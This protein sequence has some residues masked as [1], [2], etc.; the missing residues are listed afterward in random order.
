MRLCVGRADEVEALAQ[1]SVIWVQAAA[2]QLSTE[3]DPVVWS[4]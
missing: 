2:Q 4:A 3:A 1:S